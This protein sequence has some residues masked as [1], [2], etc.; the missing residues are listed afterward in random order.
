MSLAS[1][2]GDRFRAE[3]ASRIITVVSGAI[4]TV[5]LAR[6]LEPDGYGLLFLAISVLGMFQIFSTLGIP[7]SCARYI[8][9]YKETEPSQ[10]PFIIRS[11]F[12]MALI[13]T[14]I[15]SVILLI[16]HE[17]IA[18]L[19]GERDLIPFLLIGVLFL[20]LTTLR[21][22][23]EGTLWGFEAIKGRAVVHAI[24]HGARL[25]FALG[26]VILGYGALGAFLGYILASVLTVGLGFPY[27]YLQYYRD[28]SRSC[29]R[30]SNLR[31]RIA[32]YA[33]PLTATNAAKILDKRVDIILVGFFINPTAVAFYTVSRQVVS[34]IQ[35]PIGALGTTLS[36]TF[37]A[38]K[39]KGNPEIAARMYEEALAHGLLL[40]LAAAAGLI[41]VAEPTIELVFGEQY[42]GAV[43]VLQILAFW[44]VFRSVAIITSKAL[45]FLGRAKH[46]AI[47]YGISAVLNV[48]LNVI[49]IPLMGVV[50]AAIATV[51]TFGLYTL[52]NVYII[53]LELDLRTW[54]LL[55]KVA[56]A[57]LVAGL[58]ATP[59]Y[60]IVGYITGIV[61][62][63]LVVG[64]GT[65]I[66]TFLA[67][68]LGF[69]NIRRVIKHLT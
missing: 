35:S 32:E 52:A 67:V 55:R 20:I 40:Y 8:S 56:E 14:G 17:Y 48:I 1:R 26:L 68:G 66:W 2:L 29:S 65:G 33:V 13:V 21:Q 62:L 36:P 24:Y 23:I 38:Q 47:T 42:L 63:L 57:C 19:I 9:E 37:Q 59:V 50:G 31:R 5:A 25:P 54:W 22:S 51:L 10:I 58:M 16:T 41:I 61:T 12:L 69:L 45:D 6:L 49:L 7:K 60:L 39:A 11:S 27:L 18:V 30:D 28:R 64:I 15:V 46:R 43:P 34:F 44:A 3:F 4:L 53:T